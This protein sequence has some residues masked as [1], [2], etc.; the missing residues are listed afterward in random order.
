ME[1]AGTV[2]VAWL[3]QRLRPGP[4]TEAGMDA[5]RGWAAARVAEGAATYAI[6]ETN[7]TVLL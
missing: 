7:E 6:K 3:Q 5:F 2:M 1:L 4:E